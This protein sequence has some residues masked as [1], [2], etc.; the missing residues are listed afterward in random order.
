MGPPLGH[1]AKRCSVAA[2]AR[3]AS[4]GMERK[5]AGGK[6][7]RSAGALSRMRS[8]L[9]K[10][11]SDVPRFDE[12]VRHGPRPMHP[13]EKYFDDLSMRLVH[14]T[15]K[16]DFHIFRQNFENRANGMPTAGI[17]LDEVDVR[18]RE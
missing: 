6:A 7:F 1:S 3:A 16:K 15:D 12:G 14:E 2:I 11:V 4:S 5:Q 10:S 18:L 17:D 8:K 13:V 9:G